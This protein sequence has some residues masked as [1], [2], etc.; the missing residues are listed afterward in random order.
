MKSE[1][2]L[3]D[4]GK[5]CRK[6]KE[7]IATVLRAVQWQ[8]ASS[9]GDRVLGLASAVAYAASTLALTPPWMMRTCKS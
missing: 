6:W 1:E 3:E 8:V 9:S 4:V 7:K 5:V 2:E